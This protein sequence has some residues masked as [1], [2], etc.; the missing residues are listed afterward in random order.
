MR[1]LI[2]VPTFNERD[3]LPSLVGMILRHPDY[4][5]LVVD[6]RSPDG[7]GDIADR[8]ARESNGRVRCL[9]RSGPRGLGLAYVD[10]FSEAMATDAELVC[11]MDADLSHDPDELP[12]LVAAAGSS[13]VVVGSRYQQP[14]PTPGW[15][16]S[17]RALSRLGNWY[18]RAVLRL[19]PYDCTSGF[20]CW[21]RDALAR[22]D[23]ARMRSRGYAIQ[24]EMLVAAAHADLRVTEVPIS[25]RQRAHGA[26]KLSARIIGESAVLPWILRLA[27]PNRQ[28]ASPVTIP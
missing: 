2:V 14:R 28:P 23:L 15:S 3:N 12:A 16:M 22:L 6:D 27:T 24:V 26:S 13:D 25:F 11:Q 10:G 7:T 8:L 19:A 21:R 17:R 18:T 20:R 4:R 1:T 5:V 9:H